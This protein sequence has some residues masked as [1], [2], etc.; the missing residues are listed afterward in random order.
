MKVLYYM[1]ICV[2]LGWFEFIVFIYFV[3]EKI[4]EYKK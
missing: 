1:F 4:M 2:L 3:V